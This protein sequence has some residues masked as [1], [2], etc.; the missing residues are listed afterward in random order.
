MLLTYFFVSKLPKL[1]RFKLLSVLVVGALLCS[2]PGCSALAGD[3][4]AASDAEAMMAIEQDL[5]S[6]SEHEALERVVRASYRL[7]WF[8]PLSKYPSEDAAVAAEAETF[9]NKVDSSNERLSITDWLTTSRRDEVERWTIAKARFDK[10]PSY[11][12][13]NIL[14]IMSGE[15]LTGDLVAE[16]DFAT[17]PIIVGIQQWLHSAELMP[18]KIRDGISALLPYCSS[19]DAVP[20]KN[21]TLAKPSEQIEIVLGIV[22]IVM[23]AALLIFSVALLISPNRE[24]MIQDASAAIS[25]IWYN[26]THPAQVTQTAITQPT[27]VEASFATVTRDGDTITVTGEICDAQTGSCETI[28]IELP[29]EELGEAAEKIANIIKRILEL[30]EQW[31]RGN[32]GS[33]GGLDPNDVTTGDWNA[34][35]VLIDQLISLLGVY[36]DAIYSE[37]EDPSWICEL[38]AALLQEVQAAREAFLQA[39]DALY[40]QYP[41]YS[42]ERQL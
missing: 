21:T 13:S 15:V 1:L 10:Q 27:Q 3:D 32:V 30:V 26:V 14:G 11:I 29:V 28:V 38:V 39:R 7:G 4:V 20:A 42:V 19:A 31:V 33:V 41:P 6:L 23:L 9:F 8:H 35:R 2:L 22:G 25:Q 5:F 34:R 40:G 17:C 18:E 12:Q 16:N 36:L 24:Q 37:V